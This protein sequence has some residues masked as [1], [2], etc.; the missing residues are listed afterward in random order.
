MKLSSTE[1]FKT[2]VIERYNIKDIRILFAFTPPCASERNLR[3]SRTIKIISAKDPM[4]DNEYTFCGI[5]SNKRRH[6][7]TV[8]G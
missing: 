1:V 6:H 5:V 4:P 8:F 2:T 7:S 3:A